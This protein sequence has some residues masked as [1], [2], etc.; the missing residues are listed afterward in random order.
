MPT[1]PLISLP[2]TKSSEE[3]EH[4][5][6]DIANIIFNDIDPINKFQLYG[7]KGQGQNGV[8]AYSTRNN[9]III[10]QS[11]NLLSNIKLDIFSNILEKELSKT[12]KCEF[13]INLYCLITSLNR[14]TNIQDYVNK[15]NINR[16]NE[17]KFLLKVLFWED[18][19]QYIGSNQTLLNT[20]Y[21][22]Y[23]AANL[24]I[25]LLELS[26]IGF[27]IK[28]LIKS[29]LLDRNL[30][31][32]YCNLLQ[33]GL[34]WFKDKNFKQIFESQLLN[35]KRLLCQELKLLSNYENSSINY[36]CNE[37]KHSVE[38]LQVNLN[39]I[40]ICYYMIGKIL[41]HW[42][43]KLSR[44]DNNVITENERNDFLH[45]L[46]KLNLRDTFIKEIKTKTD[47]FFLSI[48]LLNKEVHFNIKKMY[49]LI[50]IHNYLIKELCIY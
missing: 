19:E 33:S 1:T 36:C 8:D 7:R 44:E 46:K 41:A 18:V 13:K 21:P 4:M 32:S 16:Y 5:S 15:V 34:I 10:I 40:E 26:F 28:D 38:M 14:D 39:D 22:M 2:K 30:T 49:T 12:D 11:K 6:K 3:F 42:F 9:E 47:I 17:G 25:S 27:Q 35:L 24:Y 20:Y 31:F 37:I 43:E 48:P 29:H 45:L 23:G 50:D